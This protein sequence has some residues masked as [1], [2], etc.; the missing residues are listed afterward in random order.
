MSLSCVLFDM[1]GCLVDSESVYV[2]AWETVF[3]KAGIP[4]SLETI[5]SWQG[6]AW[7]RIRN[8]INMI[9]KDDHLTLELRKN[10]EQIFYNY[11]DYGA[12][13]LK[14]GAVRTLETA[15]KLGLMTALVSSTY[16][17]KAKHIL[18]HFALLN[19]FDVCVFGDLVTKTKP[20]PDIYLEALR[21]LETD[22]SE[23]VA[24]EDSLNGILAAHRANVRVVYVPDISSFDP[25]VAP[26]DDKLLSLEEAPEYLK[27]LKRKR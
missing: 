8:E 13:Q 16:E 12:V 9:T 20:A 17:E 6:L 25:K 21:L 23:A 1:D 3:N 26:Y 15:R 2:H 22:A 4:I 10:R 19:Y 7:E 27:M 18:N 14:S 24:F 11:L 5:L